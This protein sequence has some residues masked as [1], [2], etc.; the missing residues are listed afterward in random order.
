ML[1]LSFMTTSVLPDGCKEIS[2][3]GCRM[4]KLDTSNFKLQIAL[5]SAS[6]SW[7]I[8]PHDFVHLV[9]CPSR[10]NEITQLH[11]KMSTLYEK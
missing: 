8:L 4:W 10:L 6:E 11:V 1:N 9:A 7:N 5:Q 3:D 2:L